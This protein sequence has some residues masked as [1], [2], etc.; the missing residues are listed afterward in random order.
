MILI[1]FPY[2]AYHLGHHPTAEEPM[3]GNRVATQDFLGIF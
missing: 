2:D 1:H 3:F